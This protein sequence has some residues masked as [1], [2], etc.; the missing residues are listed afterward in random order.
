MKRGIAKMNNVKRIVFD[1]EMIEQFLERNGYKKSK[2]NYRLCAEELQDQIQDELDTDYGEI[3][4]RLE[5]AI[6]GELDSYL[7]PKEPIEKEVNSSN[8]D[9]FLVCSIS[10]GNIAV[11]VIEQYA[12]DKFMIRTIDTLS[13]EVSEF[14][15]KPSELIKRLTYL[16]DSHAL[17]EIEARIDGTFYYEEYIRTDKKNN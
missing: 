7:T 12:E 13:G 16:S 6:K 9:T 14:T 10:L 17:H 11:E 15:I 3:T 8:D 4:T 2:S 5:N 1:V